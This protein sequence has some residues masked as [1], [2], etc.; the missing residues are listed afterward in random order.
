M[1]PITK[2]NI[3]TCNP[4]VCNT[5]CSKG[6]KYQTA[7]DKCCGTCVQQSCIFTTPENTTYFIE[8]NNTFV[9]PNDKCKQYTCENINGQLVTKETTTK[10]DPINP[11]DCEPGTKTTEANGCC[12]TCKLRSI[13]K[14]QSKQTVIEVNDCKSR[15][16]VNMTSC[17]GHCGSSS[18]YSAAANMMMHQCECCQE[19][20]TSQ[21]QVELTCA[22]GS[23]V[24]HNYIVVETCHCSKAQCVE[25]VTSKPQRRR[26]R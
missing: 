3:I 1:D 10:C 5:N 18:I 8:V 2:R 12:T 16:P 26:R 22:N 17:A 21:K 15:Q 24:K 25:G 14:V 20:T 13:C 9:P 23:K 4:T 11:L 6:Y 19:A 7:A